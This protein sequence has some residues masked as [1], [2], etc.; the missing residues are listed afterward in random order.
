MGQRI[1]D[2][3]EEWREK[4]TPEQ[5]EVCRNHGTEKPYSGKYTYCNDKGIY[6]CVCCG[7]PLFKSD[8][9]FDA[10]C[11]WPSFWAPLDS[12]K[13]RQQV[14]ISHGMRRTEVLCA[15]CNAHLGHVFNDGPR[16]T[17]QRYCINSVALN[18]DKK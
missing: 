7:Q 4:L 18:L 1:P 8:T 11:G 15:S 2:T 13:I 17:G 12:G 6:C 10:G 14:D 9:K 5:Y 16:P 3:D